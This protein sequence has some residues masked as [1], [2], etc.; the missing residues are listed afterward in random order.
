MICECG[1]ENLTRVKVHNKTDDTI[2]AHLICSECG[3]DYLKTPDGPVVFSA[4]SIERAITPKAVDSTSGFLPLEE[5]F[6]FSQ[7]ASFKKHKVV[8]DA[9]TFSAKKVD[10]D[11]FSILDPKK[12]FVI[13]EVTPRG[14]I[15]AQRVE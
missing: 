7:L 15:V 14:K 4:D 3:K 10:K 12:G 5:V 11:L 13:I 9:G 6:T 8:D 2:E 1:S